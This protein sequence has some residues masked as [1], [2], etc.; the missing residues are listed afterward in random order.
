MPR[1]D[2]G[3]QGGLGEI[4]F[5]PSQRAANVGSRTIYLSWVEAGDGDT[6][7]AV[8]GR[9]TLNCGTQDASCKVEGLETI[10]R[11]TPKVSGRGHYS[12]RIVFSPDERYMFVSSGERQK[13]DPAQDIS[14]A[15]PG[16]VHSKRYVYTKPESNAIWMA[17]YPFAGT[18]LAQQ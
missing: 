5:L 17:S 13:K 2:Y 3:G 6:R 18:P 7:G 8:V 12:H 9:G 15:M 14:A 10:W 11:Q 16:A 4:A 1:V